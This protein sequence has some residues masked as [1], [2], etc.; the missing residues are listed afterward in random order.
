MDEHARGKDWFDVARYPTATYQG[1]VQ[2]DGD[3]PKAVDGQFTFRGTTKPLKLAI[4]SF[5]CIPHPMFRREVCGADAQG[6]VNWSEWGM[7]KSEYGKGDAGRVLLRIQIEA[8]RQ[9]GKGGNP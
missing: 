6:E 7:S 5:K 3:T 9:D 8:L 2:F 1:T 4:N